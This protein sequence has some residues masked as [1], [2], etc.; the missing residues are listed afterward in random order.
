MMGRRP[1]YP[2]GGGRSDHSHREGLKGLH[3][4]LFDAMM[5][6]KPCMSTGRRVSLFFFFS[7]ASEDGCLKAPFS[8][9]ARCQARYRGEANRT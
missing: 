7:L 2:W 9:Q 5:W 6:R 4:C 8:S 1:K 3:F